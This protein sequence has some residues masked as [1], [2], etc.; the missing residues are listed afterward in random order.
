M[1]FLNS[2]RDAELPLHVKIAFKEFFHWKFERMR[3]S[4]YGGKNKKK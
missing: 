4:K 3:D 2:V 1:R